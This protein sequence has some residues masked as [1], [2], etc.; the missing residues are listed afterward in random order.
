MALKAISALSHCFDLKGH[1]DFGH[2]GH[3]GHN[4]PFDYKAFWLFE[5]K[6][7]FFLL[8]SEVDTTPESKI[9]MQ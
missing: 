7:L 3:L 8:S 5:K 4:R 2:K 9:V 6:K 1:I